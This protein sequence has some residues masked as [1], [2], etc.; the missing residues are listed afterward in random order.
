MQTPSLFPRPKLFWLYVWGHRL[1][2]SVSGMITLNHVIN[3]HIQIC[4]DI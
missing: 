2:D 4:T 3:L 1:K